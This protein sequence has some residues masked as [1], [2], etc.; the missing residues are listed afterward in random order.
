MRREGVRY[1]IID[2]KHLD[3]LYLYWFH[4]T[5]QRESEKPEA[6]K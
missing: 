5:I 1:D 4:F 3:L 2:E 6:I